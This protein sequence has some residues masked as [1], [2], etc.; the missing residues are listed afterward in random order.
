MLRPKRESPLWVRTLERD[1]GESEGVRFFL[2]HLSGVSDK[3]LLKI[4]SEEYDD[5]FREFQRS[6]I[7]LLDS[8]PEEDERAL[9]YLLQE[10]DENV[11]RLNNRMARLKKR[12]WFARMELALIPLP[13]TLLLA[14]SDEFRASLQP[15]LGTLG[16][17]TA[18][19]YARSVRDR[20]EER[21][22]IR[23]DPL[24]IPWRL[25]S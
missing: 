16:A 2:P 24:F 19:D 8:R 13:W 21:S 1:L 9:Y 12:N 17:V 7:K 15:I 20:A 5:S 3:E 22:S 14:P 10:V 11:G 25:N 18:L 23:S 6:L 4:R